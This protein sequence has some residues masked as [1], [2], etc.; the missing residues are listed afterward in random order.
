[1][2]VPAEYQLTSWVPAEYQLIQELLTN[3]T[4]LTFKEREKED[5][6]EMSKK[7]EGEKR[8]NAKA[9]V[10]SVGARQV[11]FECAFCRP[12]KPDKVHLLV[13]RSLHIRAIQK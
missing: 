6:E 13:D 11:P 5:K 8:T 2:Q 1:M 9:E 10:K 12:K 3:L 7:E 4:N